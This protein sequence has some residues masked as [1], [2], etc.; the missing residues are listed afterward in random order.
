M[1]IYIVVNKS[2]GIKCIKNISNIPSNKWQRIKKTNDLGYQ[3][4][5]RTLLASRFSCI[6]PKG[7][8]L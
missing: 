1:A 5:N 4:T 6:I 3:Q 7:A 8:K 2:S